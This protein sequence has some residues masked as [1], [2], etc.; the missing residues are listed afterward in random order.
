MGV[1]YDGMLKELNE[2]AKTV[3]AK[4][5]PSTKMVDLSANKD[6]AEEKRLLKEE[7]IFLIQ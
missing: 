2:A 1:V 6:P 3:I 7:G 5:V 4:G